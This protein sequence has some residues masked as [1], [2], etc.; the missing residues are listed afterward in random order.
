MKRPQGVGYAKLPLGAF[1]QM[2]N[3]IIPMQLWKGNACANGGLWLHCCQSSITDSID[4]EMTVLRYPTLIL[5]LALAL[6]ISGCVAIPTKNEPAV[7]TQSIVQDAIRRY[8]RDGRQA[9]IEYYSS[10]DN[11]D[12]QWYVFIIGGD[13]YTI[14]H[15]NPEMIGRDPALRV[16]VAG[17]FYGDDILS[18]TEEGK[19]V[20]YVFHNPDTDKETR[21]HTWIVLHDGLFFGSGWYEEQ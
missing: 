9:A 7:Y 20:S 18:A 19:W 13:G 11:V 2:D 21:K 10:A 5:T 4:K 17:Y 15:Y 16:D 8:D 14:G 1:M 3:E 12:G 6:L